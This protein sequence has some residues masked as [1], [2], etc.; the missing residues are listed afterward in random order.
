MAA[1]GGGLAAQHAGEFGDA[2]IVINEGD[3]RDGAAIADF[4]RDKIMGRGVSGNGCQV[5]DAED[6]MFSSDVPHLEANGIGGFAAD[7]GVHFIEDEHGDFVHVGE[8]GLEREH[9]AGEFAGGS[10]G[11]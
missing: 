1:G 7:V 8:D 9:D 6:L 3:F 11:P 10:D 2:G 4:L 5:R